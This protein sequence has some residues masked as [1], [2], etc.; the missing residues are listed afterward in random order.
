MAPA[1]LV[2]TLFVLP[3]AV[4]A[5]LT[6]LQRSR[7]RALARELGGRREPRGLFA[8][9]A[10]VGERFRVEAVKCGKAYRTELRVRAE[11]TPGRFVLQPEF[12]QG[13]PNWAF[14]KVPGART[15]RVFLWQITLPGLSQPSA[16]ELEQLRGWLPAETELAGLHTLLVG[17]GARAILVG[18]GSV[19]TTFRGFVTE[20]ARVQ[21]ALEALARLAPAV[22]AG[23]R[24][25]ARAA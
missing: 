20:P 24:S 9:D 17:S 14:A 3:F 19:A 11:H 2:A 4:F 23:R 8:P 12:F 21:D 15:E 16:A 18:E 10:I 7:W 13:G 1:L 22:P 5:A 6:W 25:G